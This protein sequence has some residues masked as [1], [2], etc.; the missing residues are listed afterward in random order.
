MRLFKEAV[1][2]SFAFTSIGT[3]EFVVRA[4]KSISS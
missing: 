4:K 1:A 3:R 2:P